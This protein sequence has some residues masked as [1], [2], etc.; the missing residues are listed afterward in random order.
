MKTFF[1][2]QGLCVLIAFSTIAFTNPATAP[3]SWDKQSHDFGTIDQ[4]EP[5]SA[6]FE[7]VNNGTDP[8]IIKRVKGSCGCT[9][10]DYDRE[11]IMP[12]GKSI[13]KAT[14][15]ASAKGSFTKTVSVYTNLQ[16]EATVLTLKGTVQ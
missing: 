3:M 15:N 8:I 9:A 16:E 5:V 1:S 12:N 13:I 6:T 11:P 2:L 4:G 7:F 14:Y 10:T